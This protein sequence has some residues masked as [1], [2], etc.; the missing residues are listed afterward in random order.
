VA[1]PTTFGGW[2]EVGVIGIV[3][4]LAASGFYKFVAARTEK[5]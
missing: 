4:G 3:V 2:M 1:I 5:L